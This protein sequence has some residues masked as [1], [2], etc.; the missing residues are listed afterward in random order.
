MT[1]N[2]ISA[3]E[4]ATL[5]N[6]L[7][8]QALA[9]PQETAENID[10]I[11][12]SD[13]SVD[14]PGG[15]ITFAGEVVKTAEVRELTG[16]DEEAMARALTMGRVLN[17]ILSRA[18]V[19]I[20]DEPAT[21]EMLDDMFAGDRDALL[22]GIYKATFGNPAKIDAYCEGCDDF[23]LVEVDLDNEIKVKTLSDPIGDR[24]FTVEGLKGSYTVAIPT[25]RC[26]RELNNAAE[27]T[28]VELQSI[29]LEFCVKGIDG[30]KVLNPATVKNIGLADRR[31]IA[32]ELAK[33][34][35]GPQLENLTTT[36]PDCES[37]VVVPVNLGTLFR[38]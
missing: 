4:N 30:K 1:E 22:L 10:I 26:Q 29:L 8:E 17:I 23:K 25:G 19:S 6:D 7:I 20:G 27:K 32:N 18:V 13:T 34:N 21:E 11:L 12:P 33:R 36:C 28:I 31:T 3:A 37:E 9:E 16:K 15:Y 5:A 24:T 2:T 38:L 35:I 14:L